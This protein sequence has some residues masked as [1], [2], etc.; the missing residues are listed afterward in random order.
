MVPHIQILAKR[1]ILI[2]DE[3]RCTKGDPEVERSRREL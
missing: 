3:G 1:K 2:E